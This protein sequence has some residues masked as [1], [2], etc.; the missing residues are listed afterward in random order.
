L[1]WYYSKLFPNFFKHFLMKKLLIVM[2][3]ITAI[4]LMSSCT[5]DSV[6]DIEKENS[7][8]SNQISVSATG[9]TIPGVTIETL[10]GVD[11]KDK[12]RG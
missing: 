9:D 11:D 12:V 6:E 5:T 7:N 1:E 2:G 10:D 4:I 3:C 8:N